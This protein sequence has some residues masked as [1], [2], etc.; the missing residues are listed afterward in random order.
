M[1]R[2][3]SQME[4][5]EFSSSKKNYYKRKEFAPRESENDFATS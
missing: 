1:E 2:I 4:Q 3:G 5:N